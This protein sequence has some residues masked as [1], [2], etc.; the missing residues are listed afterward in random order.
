MN[1]NSPLSAVNPKLMLV[2]SRALAALR[3]SLI[4]FL[5][6]NAQALS[7]GVAVP[8]SFCNLLFVGNLCAAFTV[9]AWFGVA[10]IWND[11]RQTP[12]R[13]LIG[14][15]VN[16]CLA[17]LLSSL[18][19]IG[20]QHTMVTNAVLIARLGP[21][22]YAIAGAIL[23][24]KK[25]LKS[26]WMGF[27]LI[28]LGILAIVLISNNFQIDRGDLYIVGS[29]L[30]YAATAIAGKLMLSKDTPLRT[31]VFTRNFVSSVIFFAIA[32]ILFGPEHFGDVFAGQLWL[33]MTI[34]AL[35]IIV[36]AQFLWYAA[37]GRL[38]SRVV[39]KW[40]V[41]S[42]VFG[43]I[44]AF[45]LNGERPSAIQ[46][47]AFAVIMVGLWVTTLGRPKPAQ[48]ED[49]DMAVKEIAASGESSAS[50]S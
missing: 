27:S 38:D 28:V 2:V 48:P 3:P 45:F 35:V 1:E 42:P 21:I 16:G 10:P 31:V 4:A 18:I 46:G 36:A 43:V 44:F 50:G 14:L 26:E 17:A 39:G 8:I 47:V 20:L 12:P 29:A 41:L 24:G 49:K 5:A 13:L 9:L 34:Y 23:F 33:I 6:V 32:S 25:I 11:L 19:F 30:V 22:I 40:T 7:G 15:F 37:L